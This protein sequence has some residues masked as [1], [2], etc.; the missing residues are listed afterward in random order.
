MARED[1][2][3][4]EIIHRALE[5]IAPLEQNE[6]SPAAMNISLTK[7]VEQTEHRAICC[8]LA[9]ADGNRSEAARNLGITRPL[10]YKK[11]AKYNLGTEGAL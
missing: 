1:E 9:A 2:I 10:L 8:A 11:M 5:C 7:M 4:D 6:I 3:T